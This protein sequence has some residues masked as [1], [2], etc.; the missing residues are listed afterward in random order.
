MKTTFKRSALGLLIFSLL[1]TCLVPFFTVAASAAEATARPVTDEDKTW[2]G[3]GS[4]SE[5]TISTP[6]ELAYFMQLG[7]GDKPDT[8][9]DKTIKLGADIVWNDGVASIKGFAAGPSGVIYQW[10]PYGSQAVVGSNAPTKWFQ[11]TIDGQGH[12]ISG[13][14]LSGTKYQA[15]ICGGSGCKIKNLSLTN[16]Y[17][18]V[19]GNEAVTKVYSAALI[20]RTAYSTTLTNV[21]AEAYINGGTTGDVIGGLIAVQTSYGTNASVNFVNCTVDGEIKGNNTLGGFLGANSLATVNATDCV[22]YVNISANDAAVGGYV[23][24]C[25]ANANLTRC[26]TFGKLTAKQSNYCAAF[27]YMDRAK[28]QQGGDSLVFLAEGDGRGAM[29]LTDCYFQLQGG[30]AFALSQ[31]KAR[32]W[33][34]ITTKYG[35][36]DAKNYTID[37]SKTDFAN[38]KAMNGYVTSIAL[39]LGNTK[40]VSIKGVQTSAVTDGKFAARF[41]AGIDLTGVD[42]TQITE[43][44]FEIA[45]LKTRTSR[46]TKACNTVYTSILSDYGLNTL[47]AGDLDSDYVFTLVLSDI[48]ESGL[49]TVLIRPYVEAA[50]TTYYGAYCAFSLQGSAVAGSMATVP[51]SIAYPAAG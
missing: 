46:T 15:F 34:D 41:V 45:N 43:V 2:Y 14:Y 37:L 8:F 9:K 47:T 17:I 31:W 38:A 44:G 22:S 6:G 21:S 26:Y 25:C 23:G 3:D 16:L 24:K 35:S 20:A 40:A 1:L 13:L 12:T 19:D 18:G 29:T 27:L 10:T 5:F 50:G 4:A 39:A 30:A 33:F 7:T 36:A 28:Y 49:K 42:K 48:A 32:G 11:G 51:T